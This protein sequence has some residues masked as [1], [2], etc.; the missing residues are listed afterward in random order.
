M[1]SGSVSRAEYNLALADIER[2]KSHNRTLA[3]QVIRLDK[4]YRENKGYREQAEAMDFILREV[5]SCHRQGHLNVVGEGCGV[6]S[7]GVRKAVEDYEK[8]KAGSKE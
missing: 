8:F 7:L 4:L 6:I 1:S 3:D 2:L 5:L